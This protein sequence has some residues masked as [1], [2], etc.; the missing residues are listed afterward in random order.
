[1]PEKT[2]PDPV[3]TQCGPNCPS[4]GKDSWAAAVKSVSSY[5]ELTSVNLFSGSF[6]FSID[7]NSNAIR[8]GTTVAMIVLVFK[9]V[10]PDEDQ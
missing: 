10:I 7:D 1:M 5:I 6:L 8:L 3:R 2:L 9:P 4:S